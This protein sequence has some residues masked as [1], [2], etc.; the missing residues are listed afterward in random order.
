MWILVRSNVVMTGG[1]GHSRHACH[2]GH[3]WLCTLGNGE[4]SVV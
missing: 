1:T 2:D 4:L 3:C